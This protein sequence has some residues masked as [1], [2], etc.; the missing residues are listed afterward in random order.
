MTNMLFFIVG[1]G[2]AEISSFNFSVIDYNTQIF[3]IS[4]IVIIIGLMCVIFQEQERGKKQHIFF[5]GKIFQQ[6]FFNL[7]YHLKIG[8]LNVKRDITSSS[9]MANVNLRI[10]L[11]GAFKLCT[12]CKVSQ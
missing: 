4:I 9:I 12:A 8:V 5:K 2:I 10:S 3:T 11:K 1:Q 7:V 6:L